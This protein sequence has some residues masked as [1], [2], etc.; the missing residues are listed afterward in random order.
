LRERRNGKRRDEAEQQD[1]LFHIVNTGRGEVHRRYYRELDE[2]SREMVRRA[3]DAAQSEPPAWAGGTAPKHLA[4]SCRR[5]E[6]FGFP[7]VEKQPLN[8]H[9]TK[10]HE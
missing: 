8:A 2:M 1:R 10:P 3:G 5:P 4:G 6:G 7:W 9:F